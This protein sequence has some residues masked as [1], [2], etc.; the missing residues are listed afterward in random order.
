M[1]NCLWA[2]RCR[3]IWWR[4]CSP[5]TGT[6]GISPAKIWCVLHLQCGNNMATGRVNI[7]IKLQIFV[8]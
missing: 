1:R 8:C 4:L 6:S 3:C 2:P 7:E 5:R